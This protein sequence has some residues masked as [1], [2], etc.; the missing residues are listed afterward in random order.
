MLL[1]GVRPQQ[2]GPD[3]RRD[4]VLVAQRLAPEK[5]TSTALAAFA[6]SGLAAG[7][8]TLTVAGDGPERAFLERRAQELGIADA[9]LFTGWVDDPADLLAGS[10]MLLST[11]PAEPCGLSILEAMAVATP[12][13]AAAAGGPLETVGRAPGAAL[14]PRAT[15]RRPGAPWPVWPGTLR[16]A[17]P[18]ALPCR[19]CSGPGST[20]RGT[21]TG[22]SRSTGADP[23]GPAWPAWRPATPGGAPVRWRSR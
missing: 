17:R 13:V 12:V 16:R 15:W 4:T 9:V 3:R 11:A 19:T 21:S 5:D 2:P 10:A 23:A 1:N 6:A 8:W 18:T 22:W 7:G 14:F 20:C